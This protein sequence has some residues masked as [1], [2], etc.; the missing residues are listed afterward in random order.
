MTPAQDYALLGA[1]ARFEELGE[2]DRLDE[3]A[4]TPN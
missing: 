4:D 2:L 1:L 3:L